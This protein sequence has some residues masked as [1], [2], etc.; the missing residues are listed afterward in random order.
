MVPTAPG[1]RIRIRFRALTH[2][3]F[4]LF[5]SGQLISLIGTWMQS[6][7]QGWLMHRLT[8]SAFM[9][10]VLGF[11]QF[12][13][14]MFLSLWAGVIADRMDKRRLI[15]TTQSLALLQAG[16]LA[17]VVTLGVV[18]PWM[19]VCLALV[20]G[21]INAFDLPARQSFLIEMVGKDDLPNAI[22]LNSAAFNTARVLG[23][24]VAGAVMA[25]AGE[26]VCFWLNALSYLA[27]LAMLLRMD[28]PRRAADPASRDGALANLREGVRYALDTA[29]IRN[30]LALLG[31]CAGLGFQYMV[32]LPVYAREILHANEQA[33]GFMVAAFGL[34]SLLSAMVM[35]RRQDRWG[36]RRNLLVGLG[37][38]AVG[39]GV[40]AWSRAMPLSL[41]MGFTAGFGLILYVASTNTLVQLTTE[42]RF[43]G[44][45]MSL[46]TFMFIGTA[47]IGALLTGGIAQR[48]GAPAATSVSA[49]VLLGGAVW[50][51]YRLRILA[52]REAARSAVPAFTEMLG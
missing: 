13:P 3:N 40:F 16:A 34:G 49:L 2:R 31:I 9:L 17:T 14:V 19:V 26:G 45:I 52:A 38:A 15:I 1:D 30:L 10:G 25:A 47:P 4:R 42:D 37:S 33:Y 8:G 46:Y 29:P 41:L 12:L 7:A 18:Q 6:V 23:P 48:W 27:V 50:V 11:A 51:S 43:R 20:F 28:L 5:W 39:M 21:I 35:T 36:L 32:L 44:R 24:A 22:A